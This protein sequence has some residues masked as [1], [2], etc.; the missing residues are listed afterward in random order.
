MQKTALEAAITYEREMMQLVKVELKGV[1]ESHTLAIGKVMEVLKAR[2]KVASAEAKKGGEGRMKQIKQLMDQIAKLQG[3]DVGGAVADVVKDEANRK[4]KAEALAKAEEMREDA[5]RDI[6]RL[7]AEV[8]ELIEATKEELIVTVK[9]IIYTFI[10]EELVD[11]AYN[12]FSDVVESE[13]GFKISDYDQWGLV[14]KAKDKVLEV[15][16]GKCDE[17]I[18]PVVDIIWDKLMGY[19]DQMEE[20]AIASGMEVRRR[21]REASEPLEHPQGPPR[22]LR[23]PSRGHHMV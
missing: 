10:E 20:K 22:T 18:D 15:L 1:F 7:K 9:D 12:T 14:K 21:A 8:E 11:E 17:K 23:T 6:G 4:M 13:L 19:K 2:K 16:C 5:L 3:K